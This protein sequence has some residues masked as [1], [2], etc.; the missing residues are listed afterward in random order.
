MAARS[1]SVIYGKDMI[2][3]MRKVDPD[4]AEKL[5]PRGTNV[6]Y[7]SMLHNDTDIR[8]KMLLKVKGDSKPLEATIDMPIATWNKISQI[9]YDDGRETVNAPSN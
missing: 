2:D 6:C 8:A 4:T 3:Y 5:D 9:I 1:Y 7:F